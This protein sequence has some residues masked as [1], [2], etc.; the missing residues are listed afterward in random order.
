[1][2]AKQHAE[3]QFL[4]FENYSLSSSTLSSKKIIQDII[5]KCTK[6]KQVCLNEVIWLMTKAMRLKM[7]NRHIKTT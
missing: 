4:S 2:K 3:A 1:M 7:K 6:N 5:K